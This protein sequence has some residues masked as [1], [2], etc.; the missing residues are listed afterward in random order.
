M[1]RGFVLLTN[2]VF[3]QKEAAHRTNPP[4]HDSKSFQGL[5]DD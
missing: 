5:Y 2:L 3:F 4:R 1:W